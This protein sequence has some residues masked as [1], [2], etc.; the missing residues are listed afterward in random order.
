MRDVIGIFNSEARYFRTAAVPHKLWLLLGLGL[1]L[2]RVRVLGNSNHCVLKLNNIQLLVVE[3]CGDPAEW[4]VDTL[5][6]LA[7]R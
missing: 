5:S 2:V 3:L 7:G 4:Y 6:S 1:G